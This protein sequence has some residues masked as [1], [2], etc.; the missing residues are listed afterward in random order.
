MDKNLPVVGASASIEATFSDADISTFAEVSGDY[1]PLHFKDEVAHSMG[2]DRP[3]VHG[4]L[5]ASLI[6]RVLGTALPG[7]GTI[8]LSQELR[9]L[10]PVYPGQKIRAEVE[11]I[12]R[13]PERPILTLSTR[14]WRGGE[15]VVDGE[16][17][18][19]VRR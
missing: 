7:K 9:F 11:V 17:T 13:H 18:V 14:I 2:F 4:M 12:G 1:N 10:R 6:S 16:A 15:V 19:L 3:L 8:Y 5:T